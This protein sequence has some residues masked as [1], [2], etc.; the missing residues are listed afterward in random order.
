MLQLQINCE[1]RA[2]QLQPTYTLLHE[3]ELSYLPP[4]RDTQSQV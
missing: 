4:E 3:Q 1:V 2:S